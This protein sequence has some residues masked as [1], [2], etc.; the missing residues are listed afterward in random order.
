LIK[1]YRIIKS[2]GMFDETW[3]IETYPDVRL[4][5]LS[6]LWH[7]VCIG[8]FNGYKPNNSFDSKW[9]LSHYLDVARAGVNPLVHYITAGQFESRLAHSVSVTNLPTREAHTTPTEPSSWNIRDRVMHIVS[10]AVYN[11][12]PAYAPHDTFHAPTWN[13]PSKMPHRHAESHYQ[14][15]LSDTMSRFEVQYDVNALNTVYDLLG[16]V[17]SREIFVYVL[18]G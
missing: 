7:Y 12:Y 6:P 9:Y 8:A 17:Y 2:S 5:R 4:T 1:D 16:D 13:L 15:I 10:S 18:V 3:Y 14:K 11:E